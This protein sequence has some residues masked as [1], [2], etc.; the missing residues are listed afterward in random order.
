MTTNV[1]VVGK[2]GPIA[3]SMRFALYEDSRYNVSGMDTD[4]A[5]DAEILSGYDVIVLC[6]HES[7]SA[8]IAHKVPVNTHL[9]DI[10][11]SF[12]CHP[13]WDYG[14]FRSGL[15]TTAGKRVA[16]PG[17]FATAAIYALEPLFTNYILPVDTNIC[18]RATGGYT[19]GGHKFEEMFSADNLARCDVVMNLN[20]EHHH[21][22]EIKRA[23]GMTGELSL[24]PVIREHR[25]GVM[26][27]ASFPQQT[28]VRDDLER[29][30]QKTYA[31]DPDVCIHTPESVKSIRSDMYLDR[32]GV[33]ISVL[34]D[35]SFVH[36]ISWLD[37]LRKG[38]VST[39]KRIVDGICYGKLVV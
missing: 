39:A 23:T 29:I 24:L 4:A 32:E 22:A 31:S 26:V 7:S 36:V 21:V 17:C 25:S 27:I 15:Q 20:K 9:I 11:P 13:N 8:S 35:G 2:R 6:G 12:R 3:R 10:G 33:G 5:I 16:I 37:N 28:I 34:T 14:E 38:S 1:L 18:L 30:Y 19:V